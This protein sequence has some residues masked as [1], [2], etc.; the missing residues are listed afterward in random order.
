M[1]YI[2]T[3]Y[4]SDFKIVCKE[5]GYFPK[6]LDGQVYNPNIQ[7][8]YHWQQLMGRKLFKA[9][10]ILYGRECSSFSDYDLERINVEIK[11]RKRE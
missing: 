9:D 7:W 5:N 1:I 11:L 8:I 6:V 4:L 3:P 10:I 2:I